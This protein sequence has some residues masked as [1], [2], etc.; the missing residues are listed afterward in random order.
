MNNGI[1]AY[2]VLVID[3]HPIVCEGLRGLIAQREYL[4]CGRIG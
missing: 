1:E 4:M 3:D 2:R